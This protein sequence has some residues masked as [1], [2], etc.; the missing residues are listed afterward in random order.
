M[1]FHVCLSVQ[2][3]PL[4]EEEEEYLAK[5]RVGNEVW[6]ALS[7]DEQTKLIKLRVWEGPNY[8]NYLVS[9]TAVK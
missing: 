5:G 9:D 2:G 4:S 6:E 8:D 3:L 7:H 1:I